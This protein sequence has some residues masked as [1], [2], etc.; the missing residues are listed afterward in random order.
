MID[1]YDIALSYVGTPHINGADVKGVGLDCC[2]LITSIYREA[3]LADIEIKKGYSADWFCKRDCEELIVPYLEQYF[4]PVRDL[5]VGDL[6]GYSWG[7]S[8]VAHLSM[9][10]GNNTVIHCQAD[11]GVEITDLENPYFMYS[12]GT[13]ATGIWRLKN[14]II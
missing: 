8:R 11:V 5:K 3:G 4:V 14:V 6:I 13:R 12:R 1:L 2:T 7:R 9:Y 10:L